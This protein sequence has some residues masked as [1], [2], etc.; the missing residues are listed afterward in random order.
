MPDPITSATNPKLKRIVRLQTDSR[1]R[2]RE[3]LFV[4]EGYREIWRAIQGGIIIRE[5][6]QNPALNNSKYIVDFLEIQPDI[7]IFE[8]GDIAF[9]KIA[10]REASDGLIA[11][12]EPV[13]IT[14]HDLNTQDCP[15]FIVLQSVEKPGNLG[16]ILRTAD[17]AAVQGVIVCDPLVD[18]YNPNAIRAGLGCTFT[19]PVVNCTSEEAIA[20]LKSKHIRIFAAALTDSAIEYYK[21]DF[22]L[23]SAIVM[24][25]EATGLSHE[26]LKQ[27]DNQIIIPMLG[28]ADSLNV[29]TS[30]AVLVYEALRQRRI[31]KG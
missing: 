5:L 30:T 2:R 14:L 19:V 7:Q 25:T 12:A 23:P 24:G 31:I 29:S 8:V 20:W 3:K 26:W 28:I 15:L 21:A 1:E 4:I 18:I 16:A 17:A 9:A 10:Y 13:N 27:A 22:T 11:L 6:Y